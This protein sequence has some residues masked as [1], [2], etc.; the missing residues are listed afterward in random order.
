ML[1]IWIEGAD[2][3]FFDLCVDDRRCAGSCPSG[4]GTRFEGH[5][6]GCLFWNRLTEQGKAFDLGVGRP[7]AA[8][9]APGDYLPP[10]FQDGADG[11][12]WTR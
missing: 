6:E 8:M 10:Y 9:M 5:V 1:W 7:C 12:I 2:D 11:R 4:R 3:H